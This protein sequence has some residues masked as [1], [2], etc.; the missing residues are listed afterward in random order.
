MPGPSRLIAHGEAVIVNA[1]A[2]PNDANCRLALVG[3]SDQRPFGNYVNAL[4]GSNEYMAV[5]VSGGVDI[6]A[7]TYNVRVQCAG[8][9]LTFHRGNLIV[10]VTPR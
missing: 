1:G 7:G 6:D 8:A 10:T 2:V 9:S 3:A 5:G 4:I